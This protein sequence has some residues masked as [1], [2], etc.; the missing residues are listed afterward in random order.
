MHALA[1][2]GHQQATA[3]YPQLA[4]QHVYAAGQPQLVYKSDCMQRAL[5]CRIAY[6]CRL[7]GTA[8]KKVP[9]RS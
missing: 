9:S 7:Q 3:D 2:A 6:M 1:T 4:M 8:G 5:G